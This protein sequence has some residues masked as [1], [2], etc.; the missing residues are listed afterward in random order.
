MLA[1]C[2]DSPL[3]AADRQW[4]RLEENYSQ[5]YTFF[6]SDHLQKTEERRSQ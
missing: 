5:M 4:E 1:L 2:L 3:Q 6:F